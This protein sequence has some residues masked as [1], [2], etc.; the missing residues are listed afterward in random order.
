MRKKYKVLLLDDIGKEAT[1][2]LKEKSDIFYVNKYDDKNIIDALY[3][4]NA[5]IKRDKGIISRTI[6]EKCSSNLKVIGRFGAGLD[7]IDIK[8][9]EELGIYVVYTPFANIEAVAEHN[10]VLMINLA[11]SIMQAYKLLRENINWNKCHYIVGRELFGK[12]VGFIGLGK[13]GTRTAEICKLGFNMN[14]YYYDIKKNL[15]AEKKLNAKLL[16][17]EELCKITDFLII[18]MPLNENTKG[19]FTEEKFN[20][21]KPTSY[22]INTS[23]GAIVDEKALINALRKNKIAGAGIDV[24]EKEP[25]DKENELF[26]LDNVI[27]T[28]H[29]AAHT[30]NAFYNMSMVVK[31]VLRVL[32]GDKPKYL[33]NNP[34]V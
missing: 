4:K 24:F 14:I 30:V 18:S 21:M 2:I 23:R 16:N 10:I 9:A 20:L 29:Y 12:K 15:Y 28:P 25:P 17:V 26:K 3:N 8:A 13:I 31:D 11:K 33:A 34:K 22:F 27:T 19:F 6:L 1:D 7:C 5:L 32:E